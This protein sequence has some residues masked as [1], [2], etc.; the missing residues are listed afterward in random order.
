MYTRAPA[1]VIHTYIRPFK[2]YMD[3]VTADK[4]SSNTKLNE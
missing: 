4:W 1:A 3:I 2:R